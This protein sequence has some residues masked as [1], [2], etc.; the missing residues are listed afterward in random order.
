MKHVG[1]DEVSVAGRSIC[2]GLMVGRFDDQT[3][4]AQHPRSKVGEMN[5]RSPILV[6]ALASVLT[7]VGTSMASPAESGMPNSREV[8]ILIDATRLADRDK[9]FADYWALVQQVAEEHGVKIRS[10]YG[11]MKAKRRFIEFYDT[12]DFAI[13]KTGYVLRKR[14]KMKKGRLSDK[15]EYA[16]KFRSADAKVA[17]AAPMQAPDYDADIELEEDSGYDASAPDKIKRLFS[18]RIKVETE[19]DVGNTLA[20]YGKMFPVLLDLGIAPT[21]PLAAVNGIRIDE[22]KVSPGYFDFGQGLE[23]KPD[24][25][26]WYD[27]NGAP[28]IGEFSFDHRIANYD[29]QPQPATGKMFAFNLALRERSTEW[30][31]KGHTKTGFTYGAKPKA[32][33]AKEADKARE[34]DEANEDGANR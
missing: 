17:A 14:V 12:A 25:T 32:D 27:R 26:V 20:D 33:K 5:A 13:R 4:E 1:R 15:I 34:A 2:H 9:A 21:T 22:F 6:L 8:K 7:L 24:I 29:A 30:L 19:E 3:A 11:G 28:L 31:A 10:K 16:L 18:K 23:A